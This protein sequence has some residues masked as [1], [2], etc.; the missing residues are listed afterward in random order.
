MNQLVNKD[1]QSISKLSSRVSLVIVDEAH[2]SI[3]P[4]YSLIIDALTAQNARLVGLTATPGRSY[5]DIDE[6]LVLSRFYNEQKVELEVSGYEN[7]VEFL[8]K[9]KYLAK[10]EF[11]PLLYNRG[12][13]LTDSDVKKIKNSLDIP[14]Y[15]LRTL[16]NNDFRNL[17]I[18]LTI[19][20][21]IKL[22]HKRILLFATTVEH[23]DMISSILRARGVKSF[24]ITS[25]TH[26]ALREKNI[27]NYKSS[28]S[29]TIVLCNYGVLTTGFDAPKTS[30]A[31]I[32]RPT[33]S[34][35][36]YSQMVG[37]AMRGK[38]AGGNENAVIYTT[39]DFTLPGFDSIQNAFKNW[40]DVF[41][42]I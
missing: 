16:A 13:K 34:L 37:R 33:E 31:I 41:K 22:N 5:D 35:V 1:N 24:S 29:D 18:V 20:D 38:E 39:V 11:K 21:L 6:D 28:S 26:D 25:N 7:A 17:S 27:N 12:D 9:E 40:N 32:A 2:M 23:S 15:L 8:V 36:L 19:E 30:A 4:T 14:L 3:A 10:T 42:N